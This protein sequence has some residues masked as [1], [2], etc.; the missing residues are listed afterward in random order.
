MEK[1]NIYVT[2]YRNVETFSIVL[3][4]YLNQSYENIVVNIFDNSISEKFSEINDLVK[5]KKDNRINLINNHTQLGPH[6]NYWKALNSIDYSSMTIFMSS[7]MGLAPN[8]LQR[9]ASRLKESSSQIIMPAISEY[10]LERVH[11]NR[12]ILMSHNSDYDKPSLYEV[13]QEVDSME[14]MKRYFSDENIAGDFFNFTFFG[15]LFYGDIMRAPPTNFLRFKQHGCEQYISMILLLRAQSVFCETEKLLRNILGVP[16][17]GGTAR[18][19]DDLGRVECMSAAQLII[20]EY[21]FILYGR[22]VDVSALR[23]SQIDKAEFFNMHFE[24]Y[25]GYTDALIEKNSVYLKK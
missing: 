7:D 23:K 13:A 4:S 18:L 1:I 11:A 25:N 9:M 20:D 15:C 21:D 17:I 10:E 16:R 8:A 24:G 14:I 2:T 5:Q 3:D 12:E 19:G 6:G 22:G